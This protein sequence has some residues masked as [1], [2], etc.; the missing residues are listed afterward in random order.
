M[1]NKAIKMDDTLTIEQVF[2]DVGWTAKWEARG[3]AKSREEIARNAMAEGATIEFVQ[4]ITGLSLEA[5]QNL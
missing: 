3:E 4:K 1:K 5:I 2:K